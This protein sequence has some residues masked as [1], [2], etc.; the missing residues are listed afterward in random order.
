MESQGQLRFLS[1]TD[2]LTYTLMVGEK[3]VPLGKLGV[4]W[5]DCSTYNGDYYPC[6]TRPAGPVYPL[7]RDLNDPGWK[8]GSYHNGVCQFCFADGGVRPV[9]VHIDPTVLGLLAQ[10][11]DGQVIP[12]Y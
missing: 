6:S 7:A 9:A 3:H 4:G 2:G 8:F 5:W 1:F 10:R 12:E 11:N